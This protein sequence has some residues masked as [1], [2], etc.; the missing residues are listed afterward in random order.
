MLPCT[1]ETLLSP[2][3]E[4]LLGLVLTE[5]LLGFIAE[6]QKAVD[7]SLA[8]GTFV[9]HNKVIFTSC[10]SYPLNLQRYIKRCLF[11]LLP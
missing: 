3:L 10:Q 7:L 8:S 1:K 9:N 6:G 4:P 5:W 11:V 2:T